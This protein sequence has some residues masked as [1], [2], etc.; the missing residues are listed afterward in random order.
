MCHK[1]IFPHAITSHL[2]HYNQTLKKFNDR[3]LN[4]I[5]ESL[6]TKIIEAERQ[7]RHWLKQGNKNVSCENGT[8]RT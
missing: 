2:K 4:Y 1:P 3:K 6:K 7:I 8:L 5:Q